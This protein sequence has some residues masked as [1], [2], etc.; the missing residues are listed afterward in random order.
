MCPNATQCENGLYV[1]VQVWR[2]W[3]SQ[4]G[5]AAR[6]PE[7]GTAPRS[8]VACRCI[9]P[10][11]GSSSASSSSSSPS[12]FSS[13]RTHRSPGVEHL[14]RCDQHWRHDASPCSLGVTSTKWTTSPAWCRCPGVQLPLNPSKLPRVLEA[15]TAQWSPIIT[16]FTR[17]NS[18]DGF[19]YY[20]AWNVT[21]C[22]WQKANCRLFE[23]V[24]TLR[25]PPAASKFVRNLA[26]AFPKNV[27]FVMQLNYIHRRLVSETET[28]NSFISAVLPRHCYL[29]ASP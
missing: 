29:A 16:H 28:E 13:P 3:Y 22:V 24:E 19:V 6:R 17:V 12:C 26:F 2:H 20:T 1:C 8:K 27:R 11:P 15:Q 25:R 4:F 18:S 10:S 7:T 5:L 21:V 14:S 23:Y 9:C